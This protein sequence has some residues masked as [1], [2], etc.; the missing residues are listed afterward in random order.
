[1][2]GKIVLIS[3]LVS[4][5][6]AGLSAQ[7]APATTSILARHYV[8]GEKL[9]YHM[10]GSNRGRTGTKVYEADATGVV[11]KNAAGKFV[12]E[13]AWS[14]LVVNG[15]PV[16]L[17]PAATAFRQ[18]VS[19]DEFM[20]VP[21][22]SQVVPLIG[23]ITDTLTFYVDLLLATRQGSLA[24]PGDHF[25]FKSP[26]ANSWADGNYVITGEDSIDFD[27]TLTAVDPAAHV[28]TLVV[29]HVVPAQPQI[30]ISVDWMK[31]PVAGTPNNWTEIH[32]NFA[33]QSDADKYVA[34]VGKETF[35][36]EMK[37]SLLDGKIISGTIDNPV[38]VLERNCSDLTL[39]VCGAPVRYQILRQIEL[40]AQ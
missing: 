39:A 18:Q 33:S 17:S 36:V 26:T 9:S 7:T 32:R 11:K 19:L 3:A 13:Y 27:I 10:K 30:R 40:R 4:V 12:E 35:D 5:A 16:M 37:V 29:R 25:Y 1:M 14:N 15:A 22:L 21:N 23:P 34:A 2:L 28:A 31:P 6:A 20:G 24:K 8:E 38:E